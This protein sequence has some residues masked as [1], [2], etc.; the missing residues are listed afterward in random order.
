[1]PE[2]E[3]F[4]VGSG[5]FLANAFYTLNVPDDLG[6]LFTL[7]AIKAEIIG[8]YEINGAKLRPGQRICPY[9]TVLPMGWSWA[10]HLCQSAMMNAIH[11]SGFSTN[12]IVSDK[13]SPVRIQDHDDIACGGYVDNFIAIGNNRHSVDAGLER[14]SERLRSFGL[15]VHEEES[16]SDAIA[17]V[18]LN[19]NGTTGHV[20]LKPERILKL[21]KAIHELL[22]RN[23]C[24]GNLIE[25]ILG[26]LTWAIMCRRE[27][28]SILKSCY[29]FVHENKSSPCRLWPSVRAEL[30][31]VS[32]LL[33]LFRAKINVGWSRD[34]CASDSS[35]YGYGICYRKGDA[36]T[37]QAIGSQSER[38]RFRFEDAIDAR[39]HAAK[40]VGL[41]N[42]DHLS[43]ELKDV[44]STLSTPVYHGDIHP[45]D[46]FGFNEV[47]LKLL[48]PD[49]WVIAWSRPWEHHANILH[50]EALA[51][52]W[53]VEHSLRANRNFGRKLLF[54]A[55][56]LPL[57]LSAG[58][59]RGKS[60][61]LTKPFGRFVHCPWR[62]DRRL[63][64]GGSLVS[65]T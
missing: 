18:G 42:F 57:V 25:V 65:G 8:V 55:D 61:H 49:A 48:E 53:A 59:G 10:L 6:R 2:D 41:R 39:R 26:H 21:Q 30:D 11:L 34:I 5:D 32:A 9:L 51:L 54:L 23:F 50:T 62:L 22:S 15:T 28:L 38:W 40:S 1:M 17:F 56:N 60:S 45:G 31:T 3:F 16:A 4:Y 24:S 37:I 36:D 20:S 27:A 19:F 43:D 46:S 58:K 64:F 12:K 35:P 29:A 14:I 13:G 33:P 7:P 47:P 52:T 63:M 44:Y